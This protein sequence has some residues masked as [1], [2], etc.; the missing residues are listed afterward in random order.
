VY[1]FS[2]LSLDPP[3]IYDVNMRRRV[4]RDAFTRCGAPCCARAPSPRALPHHLY[5]DADVYCRH[6]YGAALPPALSTLAPLFLASSYSA[7]ASKQAL[8]AAAGGEC[9]PPF[10]PLASTI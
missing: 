10:C 4:V 1:L 9:A 2:S 7:V 3:P 5:L 6:A 8:A